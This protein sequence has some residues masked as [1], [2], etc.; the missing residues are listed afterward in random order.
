LHKKR[1]ALLALAAAA[2][3]LVAVQAG[4]AKPKPKPVHKTKAVHQP[5]KPVHPVKPVAPPAK[6][7]FV[8]MLENHSKSSVLGDANAPFINQLAQT[9]A[10][11]ANYYGVTHPSEPNYIAAISGSNWWLNSDDPNNRYDHTN[12]VDQLEAKHLTWGAYMESMPSV[13][14]TGDYYPT[15]TNPLYASK[16][17]PFVLFNDIRNS[18]SRLA[19]IK[20]YTSLATDLKSAATTPDYVW[21][22]PNQ[23]HDMHGGVY[24]A[25]GAGDGSPCPYGTTKDDPSDAALKQKADAFVKD[26]VQTIQASPAWKTGTSAIFVITDEDDYTGNAETG[27]W[28]NAD[29][30]CDSPVLPAGDP[31]VSATWPGG[32]YGGGLIPAVIVTN[33]GKSGGYTSTTPY[34]HYSLL[35]TVEQVFG[36]GYLGFASDSAQVKPMTEF[37]TK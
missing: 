3:T 27:G 9:G 31:V 22:T 16:H 30:C 33:H 10:V 25:V 35:A 12:I 34:N 26:A 2:F 1:L 7:I 8:I 5:V 18:P 19:N 37:F 6:H 28:E 4:E 15:S 36:L 21:I 24:T 29:G 13:G 32:M 17:N 23:C 11:A 14:Y 20:P